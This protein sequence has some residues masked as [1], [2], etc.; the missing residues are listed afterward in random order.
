METNKSINMGK[1]GWSLVFC[2]F[3]GLVFWGG[4]EYKSYQI[5]TVISDVFGG[6]LSDTEVKSDN[7]VI[8]ANMANLRVSTEI[9]FDA[10]NGS[11]SGFCEDPKTLS[12]FRS[13]TTINKEAPKCNVSENGKSYAISTIL[14]GSPKEYYCID[15]TGQALVINNFT[16]AS[17]MC[18]N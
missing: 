7:A 1:L 17:V 13:L 12:V 11:Y 9:F 3:T 6:S 16:E 18:N 10:N 4:M 5:R 14:K 2:V 15:S 8:K